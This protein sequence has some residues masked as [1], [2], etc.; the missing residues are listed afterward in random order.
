MLG[1]DFHQL[2]FEALSGLLLIFHE[3]TQVFR[4]L[5]GYRAE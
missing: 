3:M 5:L 2:V 1:N 4:I